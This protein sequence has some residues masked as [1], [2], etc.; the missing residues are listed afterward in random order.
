[1]LY[2]NYPERLKI[3][4]VACLNNIGETQS[5][6]EIIDEISELKQAVQV[7]TDMPDHAEPSVGQLIIVRSK[8]LLSRCA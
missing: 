7:H 5:A 2:L 4:L 8:V 6:E 1:M 3:I